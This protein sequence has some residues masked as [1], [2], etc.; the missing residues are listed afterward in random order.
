MSISNEL[1]SEITAALI[2][3]KERSPRELQ[4]LKEMVT[5]IHSSLQHLTAE[6]RTDRHMREPAR[7][8]AASVGASD[9]TDWKS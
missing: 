2:T 9:Q 5:E 7:G 4:D 3:A 1:T 8:K 6:A